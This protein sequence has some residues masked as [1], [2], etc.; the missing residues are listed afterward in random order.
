[1]SDLL[2]SRYRLI[3]IIGQG[4]MGVVWRAE[5]TVLK[6]EIA[7][8]ELHQVAGV[9]PE[10][11]MSRFLVE[12]RAAARLSHPNIVNVHD[13]FTDGDRV[14]I[15]MELVRGPTL[16]QVVR[17]SGAQPASLVRAVMAHVVQALAVAHAAGVV[18]RDLKPEHVFWT[19]EERAVVAD[20]GLARIAPVAAPSRER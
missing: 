18:H 1:M 11:A 3:E 2:Q 20:F 7:L 17:R 4:S 12:A 6:R 19:A 14:L 8:K 9:D 10:K 13:V 16:D 15:A 5:D